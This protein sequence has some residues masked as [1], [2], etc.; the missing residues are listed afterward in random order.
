[1]NLKACGTKCFKILSLICWEV[2]WNSLSYVYRMS[3]S[4]IKR[5]MLKWSL[6]RVKSISSLQSIQWKELKII[7]SKKDRSKDRQWK[8]KHIA[9]APGPPLALLILQLLTRFKV[10]HLVFLVQPII[11]PSTYYSSPFASTVC[12]HCVPRHLPSSSSRLLPGN[13]QHRHRDRTL[14]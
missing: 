3:V 13:P 4:D 1:M 6:P 8:R 9:L 7:S 10:S 12:T 11:K 2:T 5:L 14:A